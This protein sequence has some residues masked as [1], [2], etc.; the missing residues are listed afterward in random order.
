MYKNK[1]ILAFIG[2]RSGSKGL[3]NKNIIDF[4][5]KP[6]INWTIEASLNSRYID[7]TIVS[8]DSEKIAE[9]ARC[10]GANV[11][12]LRSSEI[13]GDDSPLLDAINHCLGW[14]HE[15]TEYLFDFIISLQPTSPLRTAEYIDQA[16]EYYFDKKGSE[17]DTLVSVTQ[18]SEKYGWIV[19]SAKDGYLDYCF[20]L[21]RLNVD[22]QNLEKY[23]LPN[24]AIYIG[25]VQSV[26]RDGF[27]TD[28]TLYFI[29]REEDSVDIDTQE[30]LEKG[31]DI[32]QK[33]KIEE[34]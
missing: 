15:N 18:I 12:F 2:A 14:I 17:I 20:D 23:Y 34:R 22:R 1:K 24:G 25:N 10:T 4:A 28:R 7:H 8:T 3:K 31:L 9:I 33:R 29:M 30:D 21:Q 32:V 13:S 26:S 5:G 27:Y 6:L 16:I 19:K 11:P